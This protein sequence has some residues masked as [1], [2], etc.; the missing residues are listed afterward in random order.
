[1]AIKRPSFQFYPSDW[2]RDIAL[3][4][5]SLEAR[6]MW[7]D[8]LCYMHDG[9]PYGYLKVNN[10]VIL[11]V[12]LAHILSIDLK[13][14]ERLLQE[15][16]EA[17]VC[18]QDGAGCIYS[19]RMIRDEEIRNKRAAGGVLGGNPVLKKQTT[20][21]NRKVGN[22]VNHIDNLAPEDEYEEEKEDCIKSKMDADGFFP[23]PDHIVSLI[24]PELMNGSVV[25]MVK[26]TQKAE[27]TPADVISLWE[28]FKQQ[29][30]TGKKY[31]KSI[32][33]IHSHFLNWGKSQKFTN[34]KGVIAT[35]SKQSANSRGIEILADIIRKNTGG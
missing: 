29:N 11:P 23:G 19:R 28:V 8:M 3:R 17:G 25:Q 34:G 15:L 20:K 14:V 13:V 16:L 2:L 33:D 7:M 24:L 1:M 9:T 5:V 26:I 21:V 30:F 32:S 4:C 22:K 31:Y 12:N 6:G 18:S 27:I 35:G 10:K